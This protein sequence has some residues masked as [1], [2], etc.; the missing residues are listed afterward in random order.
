VDGVECVGQGEQ[1]AV[2]DPTVL[3]LP[4]EVAEQARPLLPSGCDRGGDFYASLD[5]LDGSQS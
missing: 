4:S 5:D 3:E 2:V 1:V